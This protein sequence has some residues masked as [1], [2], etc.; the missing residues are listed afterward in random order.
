M[1]PN[2]SDSIEETIQEA[3]EDLEAGHFSSIRAAATAY[4]ISQAT[5]GQHM[6]G[7]PSQAIAHEPEWHLTPY[8]KEYLVT[9]TLEQEATGHPL[10]HSFARDMATQILR[11]NRD[12][13][14]LG[15][16]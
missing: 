2:N 8:Q 14:D 7:R 9:W 15:N 10:S 12:T 16:K 1:A 5:L 3:I 11:A 6:K 13:T 4:N